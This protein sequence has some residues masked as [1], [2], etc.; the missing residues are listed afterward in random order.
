MTRANAASSCQ[1]SAR[2]RGGTR[3]EAESAHRE[4]APAP[5]SKFGVASAQRKATWNCMG[6]RPMTDVR[7]SHS[8]ASLLASCERPRPCPCP[9]QAAPTQYPSCSSPSST[10]KPSG[11]PC[12]A[13]SCIAG[14]PGTAASVRA[15]TSCHIL[16]GNGGLYKEGVFGRFAPLRS[17]LARRPGRQ[18]ACW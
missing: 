12:R 7:L 18:K 8:W 1:C 14:R 10:S 4:G 13:A 3:A 6:P 5:A 2:Q 16:E 9:S 11:A 17:L 15:G